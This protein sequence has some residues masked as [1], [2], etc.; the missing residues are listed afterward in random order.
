MRNLLLLLGL[1][2][3]L[4][5]EAET[6]YVCPASGEYGT[7]DGS[8]LAN[9]FDGT[10][11][12]SWGVGVGSV[13]AGDTL[14]VSGNF[15]GV[16]E[17]DAS[18]ITLRVD[19]SGTDANTLVTVD[20]DCDGDGVKAQFDGNNEVGIAIRTA[21]VGT[22]RT[23]YLHI[24]NIVMRQ[25]TNKAVVTYNV[26]GDNTA[27]AYQ[28][29]TRIEIYDHGDGGAGDN[30]FDSR[31]ADIELSDST[32][33]GCDEDGV[34]HQGARFRSERL[35]VS[36]VSRA[37]S[38]G[39]GLQ[40][41]TYADNYYVS[42]LDC[43]HNR[44]AKQ[45]FI[46]SVL[47]DTGANGVL[48]DSTLRCLSGALD[49]NCAFVTGAGAKILRNFT[50]GGEWGIAVENSATST[51]MQIA[52]NIVLGATVD[53]IA[54]F[55]TTPT[56]IEI[57]HNVVAYN[58]DRGIEIVPTNAMTIRNNVAFRNTDDG[59]NRADAGQVEEYNSSF[60][61]GGD[62]FA[63][64][65]NSQA[66]GTGSIMSNPKFVGGSSPTTAQG[67]RLSAA[68]PLRSAGKELNLGAIQ[69]NGNRAFSHPP[70]IGA[71]EVASGDTAEERTTRD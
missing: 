46:V 25:Y 58:G 36:D 60:G 70:S 71:W 68:S 62:A 34:Y 64:V 31:G 69:D 51:G 44:D 14:C 18:G 15:T 38:T 12:V 66:A 40:L 5:V 57:I 47:T 13:S 21:I 54:V 45:C 61:N 55:G 63:L 50:S 17:N 49:Q 23:T 2:V 10:A 1:L 65:G 48:K 4:N 8:S 11:D 16:A 20:G 41:A 19:T 43:T 33:S 32:I 6:L 29:W 28:T 42:E 67:F 27:S 22:S 56:G 59:I 53:G 37:N 39:D 24:K 3:C 30:C 7:E 52:G 26:I 9:C 35:T